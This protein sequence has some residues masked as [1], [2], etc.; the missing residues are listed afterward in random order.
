MNQFFERYDIF[1]LS[2]TV[3]HDTPAFPIGLQDVR[4]EHEVRRAKY[5]ANADKITMSCHAGTHL[6]GPWHFCPRSQS[7]LIHEIPLS[8]GRLIGEGAIVDISQMCGDYDIYG[9]REILAADV[10]VRKGD[11]VIIH[12]GYH[13]YQADQP[14]EDEIKYFFRHPG[15]NLDFAKWCLEMQFNWLGI[16]G[17]SQ[18]HPLNTGLQGRSAKE[19][20]AFCKK[21]GV[22]AVSEIFPRSN[23]QLMHSELFPS[24]II[25]VE[26]VGGE[27]AKVLNRRCIIGCIPLKLE[28]E[29]APCRVVAF[30]EKGH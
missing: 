12:T 21:H 11:I 27:I 28:A 24:G 7:Q 15:P 14:N 10:E 13:Q 9:K 18:D 4:I 25:H 2:Q 6:D 23:W 26:N 1:D 19:D 3:S 22:K 17:G 20:E 8:G 5:G 30:V 16:D 29:S